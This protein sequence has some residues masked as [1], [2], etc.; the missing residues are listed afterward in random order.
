MERYGGQGSLPERR[1]NKGSAVVFTGEYRH[2]IDAKGRLIV[3]SR[4]RDQ[5]GENEVML[6][7]W[8]EGCISVW[9][10]EEWDKLYAQL[11]EQRR[12]EKGNRKLQRRLY[13]QGRWDRVDK[14]GRITVPEHLKQWAGIGKEVVIAGVGDHVEIWEPSKYDADQGDI[15][16]QG[17]I[18]LF[19]QLDI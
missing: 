2:T 8:P 10:G 6:T 9:S 16:E 7:I 17:L 15:D 1:P 19:D 12:S 5:L 18:E 14:Q 3:P 11:Q 13:T 4:L